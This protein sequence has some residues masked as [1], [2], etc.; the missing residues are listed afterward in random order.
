MRYRLSKH[1]QDQKRDRHIGSAEIDAVVNHPEQIV[2]GER[3]NKIHQSRIRGGHMLLRLVIDDRK[4]P[5]T[6]VT[7]YPTSQISRYWR[8]D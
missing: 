3:G 8:K 1:A 4:D 7:I 2:E 5:A 6:V